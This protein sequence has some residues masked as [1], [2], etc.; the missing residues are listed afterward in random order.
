MHS[1]TKQTIED[2]KELDNYEFYAKASKESLTLEA[3]LC[4]EKVMK[5]K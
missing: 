1:L 4:L 5:M 2:F 3:A